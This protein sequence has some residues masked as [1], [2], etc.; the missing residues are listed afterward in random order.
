MT[1]TD[2]PTPQPRPQQPSAPPPPQAQAAP[3]HHHGGDGGRRGG[4]GFIGGASKVIG[5]L[6]TLLVIFVLGLYAGIII[7]N[8]QSGP[9]V[10]TYEEGEGARKVAI[11]PIEGAIGSDTV[12]FIHSVAQEIKRRNE[13]RQEIGAIVLRVDSPGGGASASDEALHLLGKLK[14]ETGLPIVASYGAYAASGGYYVSCHADRIFAQPTTITA[15]IGVIAPFATFEG[16]LEK[17]GV[18]PEVI[19]APGSPEKGTANNILRSWTEKDRDKI[20]QLLEATHER[21]VEVVTAGRND[22]MTEQQIREVADGRVLTAD[23]ALEEKLIDE[24]GYLDA[25]I[26]YA[27]AQGDFDHED[28]PVIKFR[29]RSGLGSLIGLA[30]S[31]ESGGAGTGRIDAESLRRWIDELSVPRLMYMVRM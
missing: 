14:E 30:A 9:A 10:S 11:I 5:L 24:I 6:G 8:Q 16:L 20:R 21:F 27:V 13:S 22:A 12:E 26:D 3:P 25:A 15:S 1:E 4:T 19:V 7:V 23:K 29:P 31:A 18:T 17:L 28:P 2:Q